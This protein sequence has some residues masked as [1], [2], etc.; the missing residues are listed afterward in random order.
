MLSETKIKE[1]LHGIGECKVSGKSIKVLVKDG[2]ERG[3]NKAMADSM[4][5]LSMY[6]PSIRKDKPSFSSIGY[7]SVE[8]WRIAFKPASKQGGGS[9]GVDNEKN[10]VDAINYLIEKSGGSCDIIFE[11]PSKTFKIENA[12]SAVQVGS[13]TAGRK[14]ADLIVKT[15]SGKSVPISL[16]KDNA[17]YWESADSFFGEIAGKALQK[18]IKSGKV[19]LEPI[20]GT[21][22]VYRLVPEVKLLPTPQEK[23]D[24]VF[25]S[26]LLRDKGCVLQRTFSN[27]DFT[28]EDG[29]ITIQTSF[30]VSKASDISG[31]HDVVFLLRNDKTRTSKNLGVSGV[32]ILASYPNRAK[33]ALLIPR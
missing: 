31:S 30:I 17:E 19:K 6:K 29:A 11:S 28:Y 18:A 26:D 33:N 21:K 15:E 13:D 27:S 14:K 3:R 32:R 25:G 8:T 24:V 22:E 23:L 5:L 20:T 10:L 9:A 2:S 12:S 7:I 4:A 16:K 1:L